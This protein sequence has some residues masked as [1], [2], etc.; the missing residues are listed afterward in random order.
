[1]SYTYRGKRSPD[2]QAEQRRQ[3]LELGIL[4]Y[5]KAIGSISTRLSALRNQRDQEIAQAIWDGV[6]V[7][8]VAA[9]AAMTAAEARSI[10]L[11]CEDLGPGYCSAASRLE[12]LSALTQQVARLHTAQKEL[13]GQQEQL[14]LTALETTALDAPWLAAAS[15]FSVERVNMLAQQKRRH[16]ITLNQARVPRP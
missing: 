2:Q 11:A 9:A 7:Q 14:S 5:C 13:L 4:A 16:A 12:T 6:A 15:G 8:T 3:K 1:M 10:G